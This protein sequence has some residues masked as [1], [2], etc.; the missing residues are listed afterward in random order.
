MNRIKA[1]LAALAM[2]VASLVAVSVTA[3]P[4]H[5]ACAGWT[6]KYGD[7][8]TWYNTSWNNQHAWQMK[9]ETRDC[10]GYDEIEQ[11]QI[12][13]S[14]QYG[15]CVLAGTNVRYEYYFNPNAVAG[16]NPGGS[17]LSCVN[18]RITYVPIWNTPQQVVKITSGM[19]QAARCIGATVE[20]RGPNITRSVP[21]VCFNGV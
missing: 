5:A 20:A 6:W 3:A 19:S 21:A 1:L 10:D 13:L 16:W 12:V 15:G 11:V 18:G 8:T 14:K 7:L 2:L 9:I 4:A 17:T